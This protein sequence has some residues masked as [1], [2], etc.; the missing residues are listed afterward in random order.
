MTVRTTKATPKSK[1]ILTPRALE[2]IFKAANERRVAVDNERSFLRDI[3][4]DA[5]SFRHELTTGA[6][7]FSP[8]WAESMV[9]GYVHGRLFPVIALEEADD[10][11]E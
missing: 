2:D 1:P 6:D 4:D 10:T 8:E 9:S 11:D 3:A 7:G 5:K